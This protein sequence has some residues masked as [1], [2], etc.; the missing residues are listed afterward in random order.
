MRVGIVGA[1]VVGLALTAGLRRDGHEVTT[2]ERMPAGV[3]VGAGI[4]MAP[5]AVR[6]IE[7][8][9]LGP[10]LAGLTQGRGGAKAMAVLAPDGR[11]QFG[12]SG[13]HL[14]LMALPRRDLH[15]AL[16]EAAGAVEHGV[17]AQVRPDGVVVADGVEQR[18]DAVIAADGLRS[19][20]RA[21]VGPDPGLRYSGW[22]T[23]RGITA[24]PF[25]LDCMS[26]TWGRG[27]VVGLVPLVDGRVYWFG[28]AEAPPGQTTDDPRGEM[29]DRF[30]G[31]HAPVADVVEAS[32]SGDVVRTD[33]FDL[34]RGLR[35]FVRGRLALVG[36]A[37]HA[38]TPNLAQGASQGLVDAATV[39][40][41][42][43]DAAPGDVTAALRRYDRR[44]R[45]PVQA[46][47]KASRLLGA[48]ATLDGR[49]GQ[50]RDRAL[51]VLPGGGPPPG[52]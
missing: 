47:A 29:L 4:G 14:D 39:T 15:R 52:S 30:G 32:E 27:A 8:L 16:A 3:S 7:Q 36:D 25:G 34:A 21:V 37:A 5:N 38:M 24:E 49:A 13:R 1:G 33:I 40:R 42:L 43:R 28:M 35:T 46:V 23:W 6:A 41:L 22:T 2:F 10:V 48:F 44:R 31:W 19:A 45:R 9:G 50:V 18:F 12:M 17:S 11:R 26:E 20:S 51:R